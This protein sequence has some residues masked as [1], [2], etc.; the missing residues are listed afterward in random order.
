MSDKKKFW[1][2]IVILAISLALLYFLNHTSQQI[3]LQR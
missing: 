1:L 3:L 2:L